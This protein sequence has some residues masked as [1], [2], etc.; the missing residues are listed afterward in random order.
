MPIP[1]HFPIMVRQSAR[2]RVF[3]QLQKW[4]IDGTFHPGEKLN[5]ADLAASLGVSRTPVREA[6]QL[7]QNQGLVEMLPSKETR[8][9]ST[10]DMEPSKLFPPI[11]ALLGC[12]AEIAADFIDATTIDELRGINARFA[13]AVEKG[14][15]HKALEFDEQFHHRILEIANNP[16]IDSVYSILQAHCRRLYYLMSIVPAHSSIKEHAGII[17]ALAERDKTSAGVLMRKNWE[18]GSNPIKK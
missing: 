14:E 9:A 13:A 3:S 12:A 17:N 5:D 1:S 18:Y 16:Y 11:G 8:V 2:E 15:S 7:L 4:I 10:E 6:L